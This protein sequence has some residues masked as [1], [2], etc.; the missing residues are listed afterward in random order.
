MKV[1]DSGMPEETMWSKFF[2]VG[3]ILEDMQINNSVG[4]LMEVGCGY[5]TFTI[6]AASRISNELHAFDIEQEMIEVAKNKA[7]QRGVS[8]IIFRS[9]DII[10]EGSE[11]ADNSL[12][13]VM[14]F[15]ILHHEKPWELLNESRRVLKEKGKVGI[16]HWRTD[17]E[18]PRGPDMS[19]RPT[20][21]QCVEWAEQ[22]GFRIH[23]SPVILEPYHYGLIIEKQ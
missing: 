7:H 8:N 18:T 3:R 10:S 1:R 13:Y 16:I 23:K 2:N 12:D 11:I 22:A 15:N 6:E 17:I 9:R 19:I 21:E 14:L 20:P 4:T 5:G